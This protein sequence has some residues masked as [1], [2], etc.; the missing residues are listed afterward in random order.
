MLQDLKDFVSKLTP[1]EL[2]YLI[3]KRNI[4]QTSQKKNTSIKLRV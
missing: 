4:S 1:E 2:V 3:Y